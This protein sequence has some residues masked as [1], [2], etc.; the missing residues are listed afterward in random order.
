MELEKSC[1]ICDSTSKGVAVACCQSRPYSIMS[2]F[3]PLYLNELLL[4]DLSVRL[5]NSSVHSGDVTWENVKGRGRGIPSKLVLWSF[6]PMFVNKLLPGNLSVLLQ[7]WWV[8]S[9]DGAEQTCSLPLYIKG[10][11][12]GVSS[13]LAIFNRMSNW[14]HLCH[15]LTPMLATT[16]LPVNARIYH[17]LHGPR[18][19]QPVTTLSTTHPGGFGEVPPNAPWSYIYYW[20]PCSEAAG[21][22]LLFYVFLLLLLGTMQRSCRNPLFFYLFGDHAAKLQEPIVILRFLIIIGDH[23]AKLQEPIV[24]LRFLIIIIGDHAAK[25]QEPIVILR[26]LIIGGQA[27][28]LRDTLLFLYVFLLL[29]SC[30]WSLWQP[31]EPHNKKLWNLAHWFRTVP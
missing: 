30:H 17:T 21:T 29:F 20:G 10:R 5:Q 6:F 4:Q 1:A 25:L 23:A 28:K 26:F 9:E 11:V 7:S 19:H 27:A 31:I 12:C 3:L 22:P 24:I 16:S 8:Q 13:K 2:S 15:S 18:R 14:C